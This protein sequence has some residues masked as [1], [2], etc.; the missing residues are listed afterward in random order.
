MKII[1][2]PR[3]MGKTTQAIRLSSRSGATIVAGSEH[4]VEAIVKR[5]E[6]IGCRIPKPLTVGQ[7]LLGR[8]RGTNGGFILDGLEDLLSHVAPGMEVKAITVDQL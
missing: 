7:F 3:G 8:G 5:A 1:S 6:A 2:K 4:Q